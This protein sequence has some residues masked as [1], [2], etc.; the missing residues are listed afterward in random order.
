MQ[1]TKIVKLWDM[2]LNELAQTTITANANWAC[3]SINPVTVQ[4]GQSYYVAAC[5]QGSGGY[6][7]YNI[8]LPNTCQNVRIDSTVY[9]STTGC[10]M[11]STP[12]TYQT[13]MYGMADVAIEY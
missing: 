9:L 2:S 12:T 10:T 1:G 6:Y 7:R 5:M 11:T 8:N 4:A 13:D 3:N